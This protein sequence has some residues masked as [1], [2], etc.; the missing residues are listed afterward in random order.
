MLR[1]FTAKQNVTYR[2]DFTILLSIRSSNNLFRPF[3]TSLVPLEL[4]SDCFGNAIFVFSLLKTTVP[5]E[6][7]EGNRYFLIA[8]GGHDCFQLAHGCPCAR[9]CAFFAW[10][11]CSRV[12]LNPFSAR[13]KNPFEPPKLRDGHA[14]IRWHQIINTLCLKKQKCLCLKKQKQFKFKF[15]ISILINLGPALVWVIS[16]LSFKRCF[17]A[18]KKRGCLY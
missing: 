16:I 11:I 5:S 3:W 13:S 8:R 9:L 10:V 7:E 15:Q 14:W 17:N 1:S 6:A 2:S 4:F 18:M 12:S